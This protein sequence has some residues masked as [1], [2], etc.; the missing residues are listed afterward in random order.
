[1]ARFAD[2]SWVSGDLLIGADGLRSR[3]RKVIDPRAPDARCVGLLNAGGYARGI[4]VAGEVGTMRMFFGKRCF[5][6]YVPSPRGEV[7]WFANPA[8]KLEP[9]ASELAAITK[10]AWRAELMALFAGDATP[11]CAIIEATD[12]IFAGWPTYDFPTV[13][14]WHRD[15]MI[16][17]GDAAHAAS[18]SSGQGASM[19]IEDAVVLAKALR[20]EADI[21]R[22]FG[23]YEAARRARV[24]RVVAEGKK[25]GDGKTPGALGRVAR[26]LALRVIFARKPRANPWAFLGEAPIEWAGPVAAG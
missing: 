16:L 12:E 2:G 13:P 11:A 25:S 14:V 26:D 7:W 23:G 3:V 6:G 15:R 19:A 24:E 22:A 5:F 21:P 20:D 1:M 10:E 9:S 8:R 17:I 4:A 18:P